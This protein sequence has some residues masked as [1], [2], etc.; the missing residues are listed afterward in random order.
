MPLSFTPVTL[1]ATLAFLSS[2]LSSLTTMVMSSS[3]PPSPLSYHTVPSNPMVS[4]QDNLQL[5]SSE[6]NA[7]LDEN[8]LHKTGRGLL[9]IITSVPQDKGKG[10]HKDMYA[11][12]VVAGKGSLSKIMDQAVL[13]E[14]L[15][16]II[17][18]VQIKAGGEV[19]VNGYSL[20]DW[21]RHGG[22]PKA[23]L[24]DLALVDENDEDIPVAIPTA[25]P[26]P[27]PT[28][29][30]MAKPTP[31]AVP[32]KCPC[33]LGSALTGPMVEGLEVKCTPP[34]D[35]GKLR[36]EEFQKELNH[37]MLPAFMIGRLLKEV[38]IA[39]EEEWSEAKVH[40]CHLAQHNEVW[41]SHV[42]MGRKYQQELYNTSQSQ[43]QSA[44]PAPQPSDTAPKTDT[45]PAA[46]PYGSQPAIDP[47]S[48]H[49]H[50]L[51]P[52]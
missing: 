4:S 52:L 34:H 40:V 16:N 9:L 29:K 2:S 27:I 41:T 15:V 33:L 32:T 31:T 37:I 50:K 45:Q 30:P 44:A 22:L 51:K 14:A 6:K 23:A 26:T 24:Q 20:V 39:L 36:E 18:H 5:V 35:L 25:V 17:E 19:L 47:S 38:D 28:V 43:S 46:G 3:P 11:L 12:E 49:K 13:K 48:S 7:I 1:Q 42:E 10:K 21:L 8:L